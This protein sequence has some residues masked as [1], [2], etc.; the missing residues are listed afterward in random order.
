MDCSEDHLEDKTPIAESNNAKN[1]TVILSPSTEDKKTRLA[2][3]ALV[4]ISF[5]VALVS[6]LKVLF[7]KRN[8]VKIK[9]VLFSSF[10]TYAGPN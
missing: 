8:S 5:I 9:L 3:T 1:D 2:K 10:T 4:N 6:V 7:T